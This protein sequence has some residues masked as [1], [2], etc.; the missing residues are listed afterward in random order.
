MNK[1]I[2]EK[3]LEKFPDH[4]VFNKCQ[5]FCLLLLITVIIT[6]IMCCEIGKENTQAFYFVF[7]QCEI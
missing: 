5:L 6:I 2:H 4:K 1:I 3:L 7:L